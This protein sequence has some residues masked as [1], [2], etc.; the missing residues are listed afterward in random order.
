VGERKFLQCSHAVAEAAVRAGCRFYSSYPIT[1]SSE[2]LEYMSRRMPEVNGACVS[3]ASETESASM[4]WGAGASG[5][6]ALFASTSTGF[7]LVQE[8][9]AEMANSE[10]PCV[11]LNMSRGAVQGDYY[12][13]TRG[14]GHGDYRLPVLAPS[15]VQEAVDHTGLAFDLADRYRTPVIV[16]S[17]VV[18]YMTMESVELPGFVDLDA[19]RASKDWAAVGSGGGPR[20]RISFFGLSGHSDD[21]EDSLVRSVNKAVDIRRDE[22]R[23]EDFLVDDAEFVVVAFGM[24]A[25]LAKAAIRVLRAE[26]TKVGLLRPITLYPFPADRIAELATNAR[27]VITFE[28]NFGQMI[29]DVRSAVFGRCS[30]EWFGGLGP[31]SADTGFGTFWSQADVQ[32]ILRRHTAD[33]PVADYVGGVRS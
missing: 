33:Q 18:L 23:Y 9:L 17:D 21:L 27:K 13:A 14:G 7:S 12:Q 24:A 4:V 22:V 30:V 1:P 11:M 10:I 19:I 6:R 26:G 2:I 5:E 25:R 29:D 8:A 3:S 28:M 32:Q 31:G 20:T 16:L 15:T